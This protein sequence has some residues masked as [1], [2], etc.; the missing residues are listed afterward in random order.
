MS[1]GLEHTSIGTFL[2]SSPMSVGS[3]SRTLLSLFRRRRPVLPPG[4]SST[5]SSV[6]REL[7][8]RRS[9]YSTTEDHDFGGPGTLNESGGVVRE[10]SYLVRNGSTRSPVVTLVSGDRRSGVSPLCPWNPDENMEGLGM[11]EGP[12]LRPRHNLLRTKKG[13]S[14]SGRCPGSTPHTGRS[15]CSQLYSLRPSP[16]QLRQDPGGRTSRVQNPTS[17]DNR[18]TIRGHTKESRTSEDLPTRTEL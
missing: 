7:G 2:S 1:P 16:P 11:S 10:P 5:G 13:R 15:L 9:C 17:L 6:D 4:S 18:R 12:G 3:P 8:D 14:P